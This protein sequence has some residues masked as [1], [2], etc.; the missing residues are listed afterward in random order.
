MMCIQ[1]VTNKR[2]GIDV[3]KWDYFARDCY[4]LGITSIFDYRW[5]NNYIAVYMINYK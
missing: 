2:N 1:I 5:V 4:H 3:N